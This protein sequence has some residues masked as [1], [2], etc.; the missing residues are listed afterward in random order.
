MEEQVEEFTV[1]VT[2]RLTQME[3]MHFCVEH[4]PAGAFK[5]W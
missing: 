2:V 4:L 1:A 5:A 3:M